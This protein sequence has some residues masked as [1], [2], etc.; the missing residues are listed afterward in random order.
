MAV[1]ANRTWQKLI[2]P[3]AENA[4]IEAGSAMRRLLTPRPELIPSPEQLKADEE[5]RRREAEK[6]QREAQWAEIEKTSNTGEYSLGQLGRAITSRE[7]SGN[8]TDAIR[9]VGPDIMKRYNQYRDKQDQEELALINKLRVEQGKPE[10]KSTEEVFLDSPLGK[11]ANKPA[12]QQFMKRLSRE[13]QDIPVRLANRIESIA[14]GKNYEQTMAETQRSKETAG[15]VKNFLY[16]VQSTLPQTAIGVL[17]SLGATAATRGRDNGILGKTLSGAY[18]GSLSAAEQLEQ[19]GKITSPTKIAVDVVG[20]Q[21]LNTQLLKVF[22]QPAGSI[23]KEIVKDFGIEGGTEVAQSLAKLSIDYNNARTDTERTAVLENARQYV[24]GEMLQEFLVGGVAGGVVG[25]A[26]GLIINNST[27]I[28]VKENVGTSANVGEDETPKEQPTIAEQLGVKEPPLLTETVETKTVNV[29]NRSAS[30]AEQL[31]VQTPVEVPKTAPTIS[32]QIQTESQPAISPADSR[33][34]ER[35]IEQG[36]Q[37]P[38]GELGQVLAEAKQFL[39][40]LKT[41]AAAQAQPVRPES[42]VPKVPDAPKAK[43]NKLSNDTLAPAK[44]SPQTEAVN[45]L[46]SEARKYKTAEEYTSAR[47]KDEIKKIYDEVVSTYK[48]EISTIT[49]EV[50]RKNTENLLLYLS[51]D[52]KRLSGFLHDGNK[53]SRQIFSTLTGLKWGKDINQ[54]KIKNYSG[55]FLGQVM[56][57]RGLTKQQITDIWNKANTTAK[58]T[59]KTTAPAKTE[60]KAKTDSG[61]RLKAIETVSE[62][63]IKSGEATPEQV[64]ASELKTK[65]KSAVKLTKSEMAKLLRAA[66]GFKDNP[67][68]TV[69]EDGMLAYKYGNGD[70]KINPEAIGLEP[71]AMIN[72]PAGTKITIDTEDFLKPNKLKDNVR[73]MKGDN[74]LASKSSPKI[75][76]AEQMPDNKPALP[77]KEGTKQFKLFEKVEQLIQKYAKSLGEGYLPRGA[78]GVYYSDSQNIF[79]DGLNNVSVASHEITHFLDHKFGVIKDLISM[80]TRGA[81]IRKD[82]TDLYVN[83]YPGG[84]KRH[85]LELRMREGY[86]TLLQQYA[87][88]PETIKTLYPNLVTEF[89]KP[90]GK[91]YHPVM[92]DIIADLQGI[93]TE[94]QGLSHLDKMGASMMTD[95]Y[96]VDRPSFLNFWDKVR[97]FAADDVFFSEKLDIQAGVARTSKSVSNLIRGIRNH[98]SSVFQSNLSGKNGLWTLNAQ[99]E[100]VKVSDINYGNL[101]VKLAEKKITDQFAKYLVARDGY[102]EYQR[103]DQLQEEMT[104]GVSDQET[105]KLLKEQYQAAARSLAKN[106]WTREELSAAYLNNKDSF[107]AEEKMFDELTEK[108]QLDILRDSLLLDQAK[109][110]ELQTREGYASRK[111]VFL[112]DIL[113]DDSG[114]SSIS[115]GKTRVSSTLGRK[116]GEQIIQNPLYSMIKDH[117]EILNKAGRQHIYNRMPE[118]ATSFPELFQIETYQSNPYGPSKQEKNPNYIIARRLVDTPQGYKVKKVPILVRNKLLKDMFDNALSYDDI[119]IFEKLIRDVAKVKVIGT[120][121]MYPAFGAVNIIRDQ[122]TA[123]VFSETG[124]KPF[125]TAIQEVI[126]GLS[127]TNPEHVFFKEFFVL[128]GHN[129]TIVSFENMSQAEAMK[130]VAGEISNLRKYAEQ[131]AYSPA[132]ALAAPAKY[133]EVATRVAEHIRSRMQGNDQWTAMEDAM[134]VSGPFSHIGAWQKFGSKKQTVGQSIVKGIPFFNPGIQIFDQT[135][136]T[137]QYSKGGRRRFLVMSAIIATAMAG[138]LLYM[139]DKASEE[140][141]KELKNTDPEYL[142]QYIFVPKSNGEGFWRV[143]VPQNL[144]V[145]GGIVNM[146]IID[147]WLGADYDTKEYLRGIGNALP[148]QLNPTDLYKWIFSF[149]PQVILAPAQTALWMR[150]Y[151]RPIPVENNADKR[152]PSQLRFNEKTSPGAKFLGQTGIAQNLDLSPKKI[153]FLTTVWL[154]RASGLALGN[155]RALNVLSGF[156][157]NYE[158]ENNRTMQKYWN[159][160][161]EIDQNTA[162]NKKGINIPIDSYKQAQIKVIDKAMK[163]YKDYMKE[164]DEAAARI[165]RRIAENTAEKLK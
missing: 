117:H 132:K 58:T 106:P 61:L 129:Y 68:L 69:D 75:G 48:R 85:K 53:V 86:A 28:N 19:K 76:T 122:P 154:G 83:F 30:V 111:R 66:P 138:A 142:T 14:T 103:L 157:Q 119:S 115:V 156:E 124:Y 62:E 55:S 161:K 137:L 27:N 74:V 54:T 99:G 150:T 60:T 26:T 3:R 151:P 16:N 149:F 15:P 82:L 123:Y 125:Y 107:V 134:R 10:Y 87:M 12:T 39:A 118:I 165:E 121:A 59:A 20:D 79:I 73:L 100:M 6:I 65:Y 71:G 2:T 153:D 47:V 13:T 147:K 45:S 160:K 104:N 22:K 140:Q 163:N 127:P 46:V 36:F 158:W 116:G 155:Q 7:R 31:G 42:K 41:Q 24:K 91:Y 92:G 23:V 113:G 8:I 17:I 52:N 136:R 131:I 43:P 159:I 51:K 97:I 144:A 89:F 64:K 114:P 77:A 9:E 33:T 148:Q 67:V 38:A 84:N 96:K 35:A 109:Y 102:F 34:I 49:D 5:K 145:F 164:G 141:L 93:I 101:M 110:E 78:R 94:Y 80:T 135:L 146:A 32:Q 90:G 105:M 98:T 4:P 162:A 152:L 21:L 29:P 143:P 40:D 133:S 63:D 1:N 126:K 37:K 81:R 70:F 44:K 18:F 72:L 112:K 88:Q 139:R 128:G 57:K 95:D 50:A 130:A 11:L 108:G 56:E 120:T 25:G